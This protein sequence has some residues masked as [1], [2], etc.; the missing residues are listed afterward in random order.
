[1]R[2]GRRDAEGAVRMTPLPIPQTG[3]GLAALRLPWRPP[4]APSAELFSVPPRD[5]N[6]SRTRDGGRA[7][8]QT[9]SPPITTRHR[10]PSRL[11]E[12]GPLIDAGA[13]SSGL[14][15]P[16]RRGVDWR[17][18]E[19]IETREGGRA[20][21]PAARGPMGVREAVLRPPPGTA[22]IWLRSGRPARRCCRH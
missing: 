15:G 11:P 13:R 5:D 18:V 14:T 19:P 22:V 16:A 21:A 3:P 1:M 8:N 20:P 7:V 9:R 6:S 2:A 17:R 10:A 12:A 4:P